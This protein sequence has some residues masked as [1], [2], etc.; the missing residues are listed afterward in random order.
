MVAHGGFHALRGALH[1]AVGPEDVV[2]NAA[3]RERLLGRGVPA[4]EAVA[5]PVRVPHRYFDDLADTGA[6]SGGNGVA[7]QFRQARARRCQ[8]EEA[9]DILHGG[10]K[11]LRSCKVDLDRI[12]V[13][14]Q[15]RLELL[16]RVE[17][18]AVVRIPRLEFTA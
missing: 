18:G 5:L 17:A 1:E 12:H 10:A 15:R 16:E 14:F 2:R 6:H 8:Q 3:I 11:G 9:V 4:G 7:L 13:F